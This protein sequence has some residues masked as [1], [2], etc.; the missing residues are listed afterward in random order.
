MNAHNPPAV[1]DILP[2]VPQ[3]WKI[4]TYSERHGMLINSEFPI[5]IHI[6][7]NH[8]YSKWEVQLYIYNEETAGMKPLSGD[9]RE[10]LSP[11]SD[12][13]LEETI[14]GYISEI[15]SGSLDQYRASISLPVEE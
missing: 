5:K 2:R 9:Y 13:A 3:G 6:F 4:E 11:G 10:I 12:E 14:A 15:E 7:Y 1:K 8:H